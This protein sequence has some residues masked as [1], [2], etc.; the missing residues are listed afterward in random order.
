MGMEALILAAGALAWW[1]VKTYR[2]AANLIFIPGN[3]GNIDL[4]GI[5]PTITVDL[6]V[7]N[8]SNTSFTINSFAGTVTSDGQIIG[9]V[10]NFTPVFIS[11]NSQTAIPVRLTLF[12]ISLV[13]H[14]INAIITRNYKKVLSVDGS[15][16]AEGIQVPLQ[17]AYN[18]G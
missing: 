18:I 9:N 1:A 3:I 15:L 4:A 11:A 14:I 6:I 2:G 12:P 7:Q 17:L 10:S 8:T 13:D 5:N 16:N